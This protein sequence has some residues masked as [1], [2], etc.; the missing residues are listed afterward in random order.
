MLEKKTQFNIWY[1][2]LAIFAILW[3]QQWWAESREVEI[4]P[5]S[6]FEQMLKEEKVEEIY[7]RDRYLEG[8]LTVK[9]PDGRQRFVTTRVDPE[10]AA[11]FDQ[12]NVIRVW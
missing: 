1:V 10:L 4:I 5:Y 9:Q 7:V 8:R 11:R 6:Q 2:I 12:Y 3:F